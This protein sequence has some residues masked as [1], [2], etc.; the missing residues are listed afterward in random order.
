MG[1]PAFSRS[2]DK[3]ISEA[4]T[5]LALDLR[6]SFNH[7]ADHLWERIDP[8]LWEATHNPWIILQTVSQEKLQSVVADFHMV[9]GALAWVPVP[10]PVSRTG[11]K[12]G[13]RRRDG[14]K[15]G[16]RSRRERGDGCWRRRG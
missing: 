13:R 1:T 15:G 3:S 7:S 12:D 11:R 9:M 16:R 8:E 4:L 14:G 10:G 5:E 6:W 2:L